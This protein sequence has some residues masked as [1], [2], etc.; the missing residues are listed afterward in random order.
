MK[1]LLNEIETSGMMEKTY[2]KR[3]DSKWI[4]N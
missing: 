3:K 2:R 1:N 4:K